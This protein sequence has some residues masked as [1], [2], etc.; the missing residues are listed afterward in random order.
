M[1]PP[2]H[3]GTVGGKRFPIHVV[4]MRGDENRP[5]RNAHDDRG[6]IE[7]ARLPSELNDVAPLDSGEGDHLGER[8]LAGIADKKLIEI[9]HPRPRGRAV[10]RATIEPPVDGGK[11]HDFCARED[12]LRGEIGAIPADLAEIVKRG[13]A[14]VRPFPRILH[15]SLSVIR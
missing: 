1:Q 4:G 9:F 11:I 2:R 14:P 13:I 8:T 6:M 10:V 15:G 3:G 5:A 12:T 7:I